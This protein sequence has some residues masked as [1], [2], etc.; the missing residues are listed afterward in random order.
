MHPDSVSTPCLIYTHG[1]WG[2][3]KGIDQERDAKQV[4]NES[5]DNTAVK[6]DLPYRQLLRVIVNRVATNV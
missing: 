1:M 6:S 4:W 3:K 2:T 5:F